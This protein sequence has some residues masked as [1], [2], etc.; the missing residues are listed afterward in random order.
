MNEQIAAKGLK[1]IEIIDGHDLGA[2]YW[3]E[4]CR[5]KDYSDT[6]ALWENVDECSELEISIY[7]MYV[8]DYL[9]VYM[10][11]YFDAKLK[12]NA[13]RVDWNWFEVP[14][15]DGTARLK[16]FECFASP[17]YYTFE[18]IERMIDDIRNALDLLKSGKKNKDIAEIYNDYVYEEYTHDQL[19]V[20]LP[21]FY[22][23]FIEKME[24]M[25][26]EGKEKGYDLITFS[27]P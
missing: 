17:N 14:D 18:S 2:Y 23:R 10:H 26:K 16:D 5:I 8:Y 11:R 22:E 20:L 15:E 6:R 3:I 13:C 19:D 7:D 4:P 12:A 24:R 27:S 21:D 1:E 25:L 9:S